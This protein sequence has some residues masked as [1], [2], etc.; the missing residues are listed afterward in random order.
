MEREMNEPSVRLEEQIISLFSNLETEIYQGWVLKDTSRHMVIFPLYSGFLSKRE[1]IKRIKVC[2]EISRQK[3]LN[4]E[5]RIVENTNYFLTSILEEI[6]Y[7][8]QYC[9]AVVECCLNEAFFLS[10]KDKRIKSERVNILLDKRKR[11]NRVENIVT[12]SGFIVGVKCQGLLYLPNGKL[13][14]GVKINDI[15]LFAAGDRISKILVDI[16][17]NEK[18]ISYYREAGFRKVYI[19]RCYQAPEITLI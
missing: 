3:S 13:S 16:P 19:Y 2:E 8:M 18:L 6:G 17:E 4:C 15:L 11:G 14:C 12:N 5:F 9:G 1:F 7:K 10:E